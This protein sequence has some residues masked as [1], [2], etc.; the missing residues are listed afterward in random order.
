MQSEIR[1]TALKSALAFNQTII[2]NARPG[3]QLVDIDQVIKDAKKIEEYLMG[4]L[5]IVNLSKP[6]AS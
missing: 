5:T 4:N 6:A 3:G 2:H 1:E